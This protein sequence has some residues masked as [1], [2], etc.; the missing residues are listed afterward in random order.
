[1]VYVTDGFMKL[2]EGLKK[3]SGIFNLGEWMGSAVDRFSINFFS[4]KKYKLK[5]LKIA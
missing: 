5:L 4:E 2:R 3:N 1:M